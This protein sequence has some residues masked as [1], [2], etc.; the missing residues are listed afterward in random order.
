VVPVF[1]V[2]VFVVPVLLVSVLVV[3]VLAVPVAGVPLAGAESHVTPFEET[4]DIAEVPNA[5]SSVMEPV[6]K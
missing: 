2:P 3:P 4:H 6:F 5:G 1:V